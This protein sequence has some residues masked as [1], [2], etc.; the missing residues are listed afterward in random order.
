MKYKVEIEKISYVYVIVDAE[1]GDEAFEYAESNVE[2]LFNVGTESGPDAY[3]VFD[4]ILE[5]S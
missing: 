1:D 4:E 5:A 3:N 2:S